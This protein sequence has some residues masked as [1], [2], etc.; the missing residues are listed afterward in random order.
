MPL[1]RLATP[2]DAQAI[3][4]V[5][6]QSWRTTYAGILPA[7]YLASL[8]EAQRAAQ[9]QGWLT[10]GTPSFVAELDGVVVGFVSGGLIREPLL[11]YDAELFAVYLLAGAQRRGLGTALVSELARALLAQGFQ[12]MAVWVLA[13]NPATHFY[14]ARGATQL[15]TPDGNEK[16]VGIA[17]VPLRQVALGWP[18]LATLAEREVRR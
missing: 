10:T 16:V 4:H 1:V 8:D 9:W 2:Q 11:D 15:G 12:K 5:H 17:G 13:A 7:Q 6:V 3:A 14:T 18:D